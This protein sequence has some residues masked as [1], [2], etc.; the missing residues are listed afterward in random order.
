MPE[1]SRFRG[2]VIRMFA[3]M[4]ARHHTPHFHAYYQGKAAVFSFDPVGLIAGALPT[5]QRRL[6]EDWA[7]Q[8]AVELREAWEQLQQGLLPDSIEPL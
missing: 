3:E 8:H 6:V 7:E 1:L 2:I 4:S 5:P